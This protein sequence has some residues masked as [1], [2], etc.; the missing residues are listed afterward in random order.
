MRP[1]FMLG[2]QQYYVH[3]ALRGISVMS[4]LSWFWLLAICV[5][6]N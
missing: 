5:Q 2:H 3:V 1:L 4:S 6:A